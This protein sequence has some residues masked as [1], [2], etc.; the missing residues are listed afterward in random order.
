MFKNKFSKCS[1]YY[2]GMS[3]HTHW[4]CDTRIVQTGQAK[5]IQEV[6]QAFCNICELCSHVPCSKIFLMLEINDFNPALGRGEYFSLNNLETVKG[7]NLVFCSI[8]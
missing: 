8:K 4:A 1:N 7:V 3:S 6:L 5:N 2:L